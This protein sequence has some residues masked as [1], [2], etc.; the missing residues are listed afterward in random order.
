M[1]IRFKLKTL[2]LKKTP[3]SRS[4]HVSHPSVKF[5]PQFTLHSASANSEPFSQQMTMCQNSPIQF[6][7]IDTTR[8][9]E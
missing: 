2:Q 5:A 7:I 8:I 9:A 6:P 3:K 1:H 4:G